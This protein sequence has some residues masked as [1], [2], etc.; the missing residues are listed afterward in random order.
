MN[1]AKPPE[2]GRSPL[3]IGAS[4]PYIMDFRQVISFHNALLNSNSTLLRDRNMPLERLSRIDS[5]IVEELES[6]LELLAVRSRITTKMVTESGAEHLKS[7][8]QIKDILSRFD[9]SKNEV[10]VYLYLTRSGRA[11]VLLFFLLLHFSAFTWELD[12]SNHIVTF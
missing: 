7:L 11:K 2:M 4:S 1:K 3:K 5:E 9:H 8:K 12:R 6:D 10:R